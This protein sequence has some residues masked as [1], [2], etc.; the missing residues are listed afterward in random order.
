[1]VV[2]VS[3]DDGFHR[4]TRRADRVGT[5]APSRKGSCWQSQIAAGGAL[6]QIGRLE[7]GNGFDV[8]RHFNKIHEKKSAGMLRNEFRSLFNP[9]LQGTFQQTFASCEL[10]VQAY[11]AHSAEPIRESNKMSTLQ[12]MLAPEETRKHLHLQVEFDH[13]PPVGRR[14]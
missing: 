7:E 13:L 5:S 12:E 3:R 8:W 4:K 9:V 6:D 1:M 2:P 11:N 14:N 10:A